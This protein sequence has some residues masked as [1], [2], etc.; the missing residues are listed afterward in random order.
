MR[1][2]LLLSAL[3]LQEAAFCQPK[4]TQQPLAGNQV[5]T[6][7]KE[8]TIA[9]LLWQLRDMYREATARYWMWCILAGI[10]M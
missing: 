10:W 3:L 7:F 2:L 9:G 8:V 4:D 5:S 1:Y 6:K